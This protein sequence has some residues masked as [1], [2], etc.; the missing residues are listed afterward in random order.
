[1]NQSE[2]VNWFNDLCLFAPGALIDERITWQA[3]DG[4]TA[5]ATFSNKGITISAILHFNEPGELTNFI[6]D[7]RYRI[8]SK[9]DVQ[10]LRFSTSMKN[11]S[12]TNGY[13]VPAH[14]ETLWRL[15]GDELTYGQFNCEYIQYNVIH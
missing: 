7:D 12:L 1:M 2:T 10:L 13:R 4:L 9:T 11:Y 3:I 5:K 14:G 15:P 8:I 6:S